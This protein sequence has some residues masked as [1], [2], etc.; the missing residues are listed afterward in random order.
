MMTNFRFDEGKTFP[1]NC[2]MFLDE[3]QS[4]DPEMAAILRE[5]WDML[6]A[7]AHDG[8]RDQKKRSEFNT[9]VASLLD[10]LALGSTTRND[11]S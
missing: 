5:N 6:V 11:A 4:N 1:Q 2:K 10:S 7:I 3:I 8:E 9:N